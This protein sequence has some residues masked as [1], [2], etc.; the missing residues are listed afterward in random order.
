[1]NPT[2]VIKSNPAPLLELLD[3]RKLFSQMIRQ[4]EL[5]L[6][7]TWREFEGRYKGTYLGLVWAFL[8]PLLTLA[9]YFFVF[10]VVLGER[11]GSRKGAGSS[12]FALTMFC[13]IIVYNIFSVSASKAPVSISERASFVKKVV[14][15]LEI[16]PVAALGASLLNAALGFLMLIPALL[17]FAPK[18][19]STMYLFPV[20]LLPVCAFSLGVSW[21]LGSLGVFVKDIGQA[22]AILLQLLFFAT[23]VIYP[24]SAVPAILQLPLRLNPLTTILENARRTL[25]LGQGIE[26]D[27]LAAITLVSLL[28]MQ[29]G[30]VWF[31]KTKRIFA[32]AI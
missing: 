9:V 31:M 20:V 10:D 24:L 19:P 18:I 26:W 16:L 11:F 23:P 3:P 25:V 30:Y 7:F 22:V 27:W 14:F 1:M 32:D 21:F 6:L 29:F 5:I 2:S 28:T 13:G 12:D 17:I 15:P 4:R 8:N